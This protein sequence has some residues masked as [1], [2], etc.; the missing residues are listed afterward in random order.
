MEN[1]EPSRYH[2]IEK[3]VFASKIPEH[4]L[5]KLDD[6]ER[7]LL[8]QV[9][10][11]GGKADWLIERAVESNQIAIEVDARLTKVE[12]WKTMVTG[13]GA[14]VASVGV[15][16]FTAFASAGTRLLLEHLFGKHGP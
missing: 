14:V 2:R 12:N 16:I 3:P 1:S 6:K 9:S 7:Y 10:T 15:L 8:D 4:L 5:A 13:K 11:L